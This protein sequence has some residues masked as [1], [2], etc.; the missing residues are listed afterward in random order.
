MRISLLCSD[1][2]HPVNAYLQRWISVQQGVHDVELVRRKSELSGGDIL[3]LISCA[4]IVGQ[5]DRSA[6][7][8]T[9]VLHASDLPRGRGWNPHVWQLFE[10]AEEITVS[11]LEAEDKVD[12]GRIWKKLKFPVPK[13]MLWDEI[14]ARLFDA[15]IQLIDFALSEFEKISPAIQDL[16]IEPTYYPR[17]KPADS[18]IDPSQSIAS[19]FNRIRVCD[20]NRFPA[21]FELH[22]KKYK[23][24]LE[25]IDD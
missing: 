1:E 19:Q 12:S 15:E 11:L 2:Q 6:Y 22:G 5:A 17:R 7:R 4:E 10:G 25:K 13:H 8:A 14:N 9:L 23:L 24:I 18:R 16:S 21:F 20:P 3:F